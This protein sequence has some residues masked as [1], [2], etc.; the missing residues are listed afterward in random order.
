MWPW[1]SCSLRGGIVSGSIFDRAKLMARTVAERIAGLVVAK[2]LPWAG[3]SSS[4]TQETKGADMGAAGLKLAIVLAA[5]LCGDI[6]PFAARPALSGWDGARSRLLHRP[7][8][9][10]TS[11][12]WTGR[13][14][15]RLPLSLSS[16]STGW[17]PA[18]SR[19]PHRQSSRRATSRRPKRPRPAHSAGKR[20]CSAAEFSGWPAAATIRPTT[21]IRTAANPR[22]GGLLQRREGE[23]A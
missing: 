10:T 8:G 20:L 6:A 5:W 17:R 18:S 16:A 23:Q 14:A 11:S 7:L 3:M 21:G 1:L 19:R 4:K 13:S 12:S 22:A 9:E 15:E 2:A